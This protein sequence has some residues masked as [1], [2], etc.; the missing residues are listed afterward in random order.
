MWQTSDSM[1]STGSPVVVVVGVGASKLNTLN[2]L[3]LPTLLFSHQRPVSSPSSPSSSFMSASSINSFDVLYNHTGSNGGSICPNR[4][5]PR[6]T[7][8]RQILG[9]TQAR[10]V[11]CARHSAWLPR[12]RSA[13]FLP[14]HLHRTGAQQT[15]STVIIESGRNTPRHGPG[16]RRP[17]AKTPRSS[18]A[19]AA[20]ASSFSVARCAL[21]ACRHVENTRASYRRCTAAL[22]CCREGRT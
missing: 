22:A 12:T 9:S 6:K 7:P 1:A 21:C 15:F 20:F 8:E 5:H 2:R 3:A 4:T 13:R 16:N 11:I 17:R 19:C 14:G 10:I 18:V